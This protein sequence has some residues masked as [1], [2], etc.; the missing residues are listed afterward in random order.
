V[1]VQNTGSET[2]SIAFVFSKPGWEQFARETTV[3]EG[4]PV[5]PLSP[6]ELTEIRKRH[7]WHMVFERP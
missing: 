2:L 6:T 3:V 5:I 7:E 1:A 4:Q